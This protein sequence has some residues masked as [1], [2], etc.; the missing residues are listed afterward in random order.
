MLLLIFVERRVVSKF[1]G[2]VSRSHTKA[3]LPLPQRRPQEM[4][5]VGFVTEFVAVGAAVVEVVASVVAE[6]KN[7]EVHCD[8]SLQS[9]RC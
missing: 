8:S 3:I 4:L 7:E 5:G 1:D 2:I 6:Q 9:G